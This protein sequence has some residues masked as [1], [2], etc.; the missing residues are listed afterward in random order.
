MNNPLVSIVVPVYNAHDYLPRCIESLLEQT[1]THL[2][3]IL[4]D[5]G[6]TDSSGAICDNYTT[7]P[8]VH[9]IHKPNGGISSARNAGL[10]VAKGDYITFCDS[11]DYVHPQMIELLVHTSIEKG[12]DLTI[13]GISFINDEAYAATSLTQY[14]IQDVVTHQTSVLDQR[15]LYQG[16]FSGNNFFPYAVVW[17]KLF[18]RSLL[19]GIRYRGGSHFEDGAFNAEVFQRCQKAYFIDLPLYIY[20]VHNTSISH[21]NDDGLPKDTDAQYNL[22]LNVLNNMPPYAAMCLSFIYRNLLFSMFCAHGTGH[23]EAVRNFIRQFKK[24]SYKAF[25]TNRYIPLSKKAQFVIFFH[26]P[27]FYRFCYYYVLP[28]LRHRGKVKMGKHG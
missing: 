2:E 11:D 17:N 12:C 26:C 28:L 23:E 16:L 6:S 27:W 25:L 5:D 13:C 8:R 15:A 14:D 3:V 18:S 4:V 24:K 21:S 10:D 7:N 19:D 9:V 1:Y 22:Y 20:I